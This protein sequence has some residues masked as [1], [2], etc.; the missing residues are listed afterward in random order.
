MNGVDLKKA[1]KKH[2]SIEENLQ[3]AMKLQ[4]SFLMEQNLQVI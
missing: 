2:L 4:L 3:L 1:K